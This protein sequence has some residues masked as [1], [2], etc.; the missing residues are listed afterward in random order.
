MK[1]GQGLKLFPVKTQYN[2]SIGE[3][4]LDLVHFITNMFKRR[5]IQKKENEYEKEKI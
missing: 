5:I 3:P 1:R 2:L 4:K